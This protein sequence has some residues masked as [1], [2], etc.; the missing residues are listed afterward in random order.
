MYTYS[1]IQYSA[2]MN[3]ESQNGISSKRSASCMRENENKSNVKRRRKEDSPSSISDNHGNKAQAIC[4]SENLEHL[5]IKHN[6]E[7]P[8]DVIIKVEDW[9]EI[10]DPCSAIVQNQ[11]TGDEANLLVLY[12]DTQ[13]RLITFDI[14]E[15]QCTVQ[16]L[17]KV[18]IILINFVF[19]LLF[20]K[21]SY[22]T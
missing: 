14:P 16:D 8:M 10:N 1:I 9:Q 11:V 17:L 5:K 22:Y 2:N 3:L 21:Y 7:E 15:E 18:V 4:S 19:L 6:I 12:A 13:Q 20:F